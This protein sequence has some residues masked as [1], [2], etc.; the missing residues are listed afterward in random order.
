M[1]S[2]WRSLVIAGPILAVIFVIARFEVSHRFEARQLRSDLQRLKE[3]GMELAEER[4][5]VRNFKRA[6]RR[7]SE[8]VDLVN[9]V[10]STRQEL[11]YR[12]DLLVLLQKDV[13]AGRSI[14]RLT[15]EGE[16]VGVE[17][18]GGD[19]PHLQ[20][21]CVAS[22]ASGDPPTGAEPTVVHCTVG[23]GITPP[24]LEAALSRLVSKDAAP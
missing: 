15:L 14:H 5:L 11:P 8:Q 17:Y 22:E 4:A 18:S 16:D 2:L 6:N 13:P 10:R 24:W 12:G 23:A 19:W 21:Q 3:E 9:A 1:T 20:D 7:L